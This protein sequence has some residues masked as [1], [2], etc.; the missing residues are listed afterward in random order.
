MNWKE[1]ISS[2]S[3]V[4]KFC[5]LRF[6]CLEHINRMKWK[7]YWPS[8]VFLLLRM[9]EFLLSSTKKE[10]KASYE[11]L[12]LKT[13][14]NP[15]RKMFRNNWTPA[16]FLH[17]VQV[18][19]VC[20]STRTLH[21]S[22]NWQT[23]RTR[24]TLIFRLHYSCC[25]AR[26]RWKSAV[27]FIPRWQAKDKHLSSRNNN[28]REWIEACCEFLQFCSMQWL[29]RDFKEAC[30][31]FFVPRPLLN[32]YS[33]HCTWLPWTRDEHETSTLISWLSIYQSF[34]VLFFL[35]RFLIP[36]SGGFLNIQIH[37]IKFTRGAIWVNLS[38]KK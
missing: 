21:L 6:I 11:Q 2:H 28:S 30:H 32:R 27:L 24:T 18:H 37:L 15:I 25:L 5:W 20:P 3:L 13:Y 26:L 38:Q 19:F 29:T 22:I 35:W 4:W 23:A 9:Q 12:Q 14:W 36:R 1:T 16:L 7:I 34:V 10:T 33:L 8:G 17:T 31:W